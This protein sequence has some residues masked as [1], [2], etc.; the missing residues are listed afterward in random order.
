MLGFTLNAINNDSEAL[1]RVTSVSVIMP[2]SERSILGL[3]SSCLIW[4]IALLIAS[5]DPCTSDLII[6]FSSSDVASLNA[7]SCVTNVNGF[8]PSFV[9]WILAS[10]KFFASFSFGKTIKSSPAFDAPF[11]PIIST[12]VAGSAIS[13]FFPWSFI[14]ALTLPHFSPLTKKSPFLKVPAVIITFTT[15]PLPISIFDS[16]TIPFASVSKSV[17]KSNN[18]AWRT[19]EST[20]FS[21]FCLVLVEIST[22]KVSPERSSAINSYSNNWFFIFCGSA[23][24]RSHL[25]IATTIGTPAA[26]ACFID[27]IVWG[28]TPSSAATTKITMSVNLDPLALI[29]VNAA[30]PGVSIKVILLELWLI[31]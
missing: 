6:I 16:N 31:W 14:I 27:S 20:S 7:E 9:S 28:L 3:T 23:S 2:I 13:I 10:H 12:G 25:F 18:S 1:A 24:E 19:I 17:F 26:L 22:I 30:W 8:L 4:L 11:I 29:S 21:R 15:G 5:E